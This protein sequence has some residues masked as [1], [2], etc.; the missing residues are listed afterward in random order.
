MKEPIRCR[1]RQ[2]KSLRHVTMVAKSVVATSLGH[3][4]CM[5]FQRMIAQTVAHAF[6]PSFGNANSRL[7]QERFLRSR[8]SATMV[9]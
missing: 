9:T 1:N 4:T 8:N 3:S 6:L 7:C 5:T 2:D